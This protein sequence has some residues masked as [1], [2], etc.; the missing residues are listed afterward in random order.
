VPDVTGQQKMLLILGTLALFGWF[1]LII[2]AVLFPH[3]ITP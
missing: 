2:L 1:A 3:G